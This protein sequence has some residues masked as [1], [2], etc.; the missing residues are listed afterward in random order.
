[1]I[2]K[3]IEWRNF[4]SY[5]NIPTIIN[6]DSINSVNLIIGDNG[7]GKSSIEEVIKEREKLSMEEK[8]D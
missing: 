6:F 1:M 7:T 3:S 2:L 8:N 5:S 4:K